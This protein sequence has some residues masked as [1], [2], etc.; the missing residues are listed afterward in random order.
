MNLY[1]KRG[2]GHGPESGDCSG[3]GHFRCVGCQCD[4]CVGAGWH[5]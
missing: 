4:E 5:E 2:M 1:E 3:F